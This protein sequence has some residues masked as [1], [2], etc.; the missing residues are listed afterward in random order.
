MTQKCRD[1][2]YPK[3]FKEEALAEREIKDRIMP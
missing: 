3:A 2:Q 1:K